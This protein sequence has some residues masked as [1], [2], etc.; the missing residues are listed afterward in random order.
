MKPNSG[1]GG[2]VFLIMPS[3]R[4]RHP[5]T[6]A[7]ASPSSAT[8]M[9]VWGP[10]MTVPCCCVFVICCL[11]R[12]AGQNLL[13]PSRFCYFSHA[14]SGPSPITPLVAHPASPRHQLASPTMDMPSS[15]NGSS[16][17]MDMDIQMLPYL[18]FQG[19]DF[20]LF[21][22]WVPR[23]SGAI[24]GACIGLVVFAILE[25]LVTAWRSRLEDSWAT[26]CVGSAMHAGT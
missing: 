20:L 3:L 16:S 11:P 5:D 25:R 14:Q 2:S 6:P 13:S 9:G 19:G 22:A 10:P 15:D 18:H 1:E 24:A 21:K 4:H 17:S 8:S 23:S 12:R 26:R 7:I